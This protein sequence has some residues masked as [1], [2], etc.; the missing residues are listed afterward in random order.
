MNNTTAFNDSSTKAMGVTFS[1]GPQSPLSTGSAT[2]GRF[3]GAMALITGL[4]VASVTAFG[5]IGFWIDC[6]YSAD[7]FL[8]GIMGA[9]I[10]SAIGLVIGAVAG[11]AASV[12]LRL[13]TLPMGL[14][15]AGAAAIA[16]FSLTFGVP[17]LAI[18]VTA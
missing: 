9:L 13:V 17:I 5:L 7:E 11:V 15:A 4:S 8:N 12:K 1:R 16:A 6:A 18:A 14:M 2:A 10:G 3:L